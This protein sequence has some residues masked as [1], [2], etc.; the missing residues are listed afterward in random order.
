M[1]NDFSKGTDRQRCSWLAEQIVKSC[2]ADRDP[3]SRKIPKLLPHVSKE[4]QAVGPLWKHWFFVKKLNL[5]VLPF[6]SFLLAYTSAPPHGSLSLP[7]LSHQVLQYSTVSLTVHCIGIASCEIL[8]E[9]SNP[10]IIAS[11]TE[12]PEQTGMSRC[13]IEQNPLLRNSS[14]NYPTGFLRESAHDIWSGS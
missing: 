8:Q 1:G 10:S 3:C 13:T 12:T 4:I 6:Y 11:D 14:W 7:T 2:T 5:S 9:P